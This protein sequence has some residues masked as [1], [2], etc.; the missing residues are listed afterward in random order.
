MGFQS[1]SLFPHFAALQAGYQIGRRWAEIVQHVSVQPRTEPSVMAFSLTLQRLSR[2]A[3]R[4]LPHTGCAL[5]A[6]DLLDSFAGTEQELVTLYYAH[7]N[8]INETL[9]HMH[10]RRVTKRIA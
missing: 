8:E 7:L 5:C 3:K 10:Q 4:R 2:R 1:S 6:H 9:Q